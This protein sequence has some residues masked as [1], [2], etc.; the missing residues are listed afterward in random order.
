MKN[1]LKG[2]VTRIKEFFREPTWIEHEEKMLR[3]LVENTHHPDDMQELINNL[4]MQGKDKKAEK[5]EKEFKEH[6]PDK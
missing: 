1:P 6:W 4:K 3:K 2:P 5:V